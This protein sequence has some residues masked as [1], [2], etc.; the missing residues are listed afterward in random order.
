MVAMDKI[1]E[2]GRQIG[3][4]FNAERVILFGSY[5]RGDY[6]EGSDLDVLIV[7]E[8]TLKN[9]NVE[10]KIDHRDF[11]D[12]ADLLR[13]LGHPVLVTNYGEFFRLADEGLKAPA[14]RF[15]LHYPSL[16]LQD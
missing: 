11:L 5:A 7:L 15:L 1:E 8:M 14:K 12:R 10:G 13:T 9:L 6:H 4:Q 2:F 3:R 16:P